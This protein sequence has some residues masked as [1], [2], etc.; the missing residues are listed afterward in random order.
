MTIRHPTLICVMA[1]LMGAGSLCAQVD[2]GTLAG[3]VTDATA[4]SIPGATVSVV[5]VATGVKF[6]TTTNAKGEFV[7]PDLN[8][9]QYRVIVSHPGFKTLARQDLVV[10]ANARLA[11]ALTLELGAVTQ[12]VE[13][14]GAVTPLLQRESST[15][16]NV[17]E[18]RQVTELPTLDRTIFNLA[19]L[20]PGVVQANLQS[21]ST[22]IP[23]NG[24]ASVG[25]N[26]N[27]L[28]NFNA[29]NSFILD[30]VNNTFAAGSSSYPGI[31]PPLEAI[32]EFTI[33]TSGSAAEM[34]RGG[35]TV[36]VTLKS[37]TNHLHGSVFE[38]LRNSALD[39]RNF[40]DYTTA[41]TPNRLPN[42]IQ[43]QFGGTVGG[44]I[45]KDRTFFFADYQGF[46]QRQGQTWVSTVPDAAVRQGDFSH[47]SQPIFDPATY[48]AATNTRQPFPGNIINPSRLNPAALK[49]LNFYPLPND[50]SGAVTPL[51]AGK[52]FSASTLDRTQDAFD[53]K[54]DH[55]ISERDSLTGRYSYGRSHALLPG[56]F[57]DLPQYAPAQGKALLQ[58]VNSSQYLPGLVSNPAQSAGL[59]WIHNFG[60]TILNEMRTSWLRTGA[61]A[62][63]LG[64]GHNYADQLGIPNANVDA[65]NGGFPSM[66]I[67]GITGVGESGANPLI[68]I[69]NSFQYLD[70]L[71][72]IHGSH[73]FKVGV[74]VI[75]QRWTFLQH[76]T[77][78]AA[79]SF[80]F[81]QYMTADPGN[82]NAT[83]NAMASFLLGIPASASLGRETGT[84][85]LR[86]WEDAGYFQDTWKV[87][88]KLTMNYGLRYEV[89]TPMV[90]VHNRMTNFDPATGTLVLAGQGPSGSCLST[91]ALMCTD[92][93]NFEPRLGF[94]YQATPKLVLRADY[95][96]QSA[97]G[98]GKSLGFKVLNPPFTG[99]VSF[100]NTAVPQQITR[101]LDQGFPTTNPFSSI[102]DPT[103]SI[104][105]NPADP[106]HA[107]TQQWSMGFQDELASNLVLEVNYVGNA[108][109]HYDGQVDSYNLNP[110]KPGTGPVPN[111][112]IYFNTIP[113]GVSV[114]YFDSNGRAHYNGLQASLTK[115]FSGGLT[116]G[117]NYTWSHV[118]GSIPAQYSIEQ[119]FANTQIDTRNRAT[120]NWLYDLPIGRGRRFGSSLHPVLNG[121]VGGWRLGGVLQFQSGFPYTVTGGAGNPNR[122]CNGQTPP[123]GHTVQEWFDTSCFPL[124]EPV[125]DLVH[126]GQ[127]IP[128]GTSGFYILTGDGI[129]EVDLSLTKSFNVG[130]EGR[131]IEFRAEAFNVINNP[132]F[133]PPLAR[134][135]SGTEGLVVGARPARQIQLAL[136]YSF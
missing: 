7:A 102:N 121:I 131:K 17:L 124:P 52:F 73:T 110:A 45:R 134:I 46:R 61:D 127:Y 78:I 57:T 115:R 82:L 13:V 44:P 119:T 113:S 55:R 93:K 76:L 42:F 68:S 91:R 41:A 85:G 98:D 39:A 88:R 112:T 24:R 65:W 26:A 126:G 129:R 5:N 132:Q 83:G 79:G 56:A 74:N 89:F 18:T 33:D 105:A 50:P 22:G 38:F 53:V 69:E 62:T 118:L 11:V 90:E 71:T 135:G 101:T 20:T 108:G 15:V 116:F 95:A 106:A 23:D 43:N 117:A 60:P 75:R 54:I 47:T 14:K 66:S 100:F 72:L 30:G 130:A 27:G 136:K 97:E 29:V 94:A 36:M 128:F 9:G 104:H 107:Y 84:F 122:T 103:A 125:P 34:G 123:G 99:G 133:L 64:F 111:R 31:L 81:D 48:N 92:W 87:S 59:G 19:M 49:V 10:Q 3:T 28:G 70:N 63:Q 114:S 86:W 21:N 96:L 8:P 80:S 120:A 77:G 2:R 58:G 67:T 1:I 32:Q 12:T 37:G 40:F 109:T 25:L 35:T 4:A 51:G 16:T 6:Q